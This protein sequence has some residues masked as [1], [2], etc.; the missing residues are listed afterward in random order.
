MA[1]PIP[2]PESDTAPASLRRPLATR[3][4]Y[5]VVYRLLAP[6][7]RS[8]HPPEYTARGVLF[9][10]L[11][12]LTPTVGVQMLIVLGMWALVRA[13]R[14]A[15]DFNL[16]VGCAWTWVTNIITVP[17]VYF[18]F[19]I[20]GRVMMGQWDDIGGYGEFSGQLSGMLSSQL[21]F[22]ESLWLYTVELFRVW[23]LPMFVGSIPWAIIGSWAGYRWSLGL[24][25][26]FGDRRR[27]RAARRREARRQAAEE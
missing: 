18:L 5:M 26:R 6:I 1:P 3:L 17:P 2:S 19:L 11:A 25:R 16:I 9:G 14:P 10:L 24:M 8:K 13:F 20:T 7:L 23:G 21:D 22:F 15:W 27:N 4:R 12:A